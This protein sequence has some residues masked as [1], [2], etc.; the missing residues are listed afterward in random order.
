MYKL[1]INLLTLIISHLSA[2]VNSFK[3]NLFDLLL[4]FKCLVL[5]NY[6]LH[7]LV[8]NK[9]AILQEDEGG[10]EEEEQEVLVDESKQNIHLPIEWESKWPMS[11]VHHCE[12]PVKVEH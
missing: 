10:H 1:K 12:D 8:E 3:L 6:A 11:I 2:S 4:L 7:L 5:F 9:E